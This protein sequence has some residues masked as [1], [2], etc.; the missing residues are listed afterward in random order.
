MAALRHTSSAATPSCAWYRINAI[1]YSLNRDRFIASSPRVPNRQTYRDF[2]VHHGPVFREQVICYKPLKLL[3]ETAMVGLGLGLI[4]KVQRFIYEAGLKVGMIV[5]PDS[6]YSPVANTASLRRKREWMHRSSLRGLDIDLDGQMRRLRDMCLPYQREY[7]GNRHL[8]EAMAGNFGPG[9]GYIEA[10]ALHAAVRWLK[11][12]R[13][14]EVGSGTSTYCML[15]ACQLNKA[16]SGQDAEIT[17]IEPYPSD[18]L[19]GAPVQLIKKPVQ[20]VNP[21]TFEQLGANDLLFIDSTHA[22][23]IG[24]DVPFLYLEVLPRLRQGVMIHIHDIYLPYDYQRDADRALFQWM[25]TS[26]LQAFL[27]FNNCFRIEI[28]LSHLHYDRKDELREVFPEYVGQHDCEGLIDY[29]RNGGA[30]HFPASTYLRC[31]AASSSK[32]L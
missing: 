18:W 29:S 7:E 25:E 30:G 10:Q 2:L 4:P 24:G 19:L 14:I 11:P 22:V 17:C 1:C 27:V 32:S 26:L 28:C 9:F 5:L 20:E 6:Y 23:R 13:I 16:E 3:R 15:E 31:I 12:N 21:G 8:L